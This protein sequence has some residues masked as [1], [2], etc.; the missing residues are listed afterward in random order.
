MRAKRDD[1]LRL[2]NFA[3]ELRQSSTDSESRLWS[4]VRSRQL[5]GYK[6]RRQH[7]LGGY[8][9]DFYCIREKFAVELD[10]GQHTEPGGV[11]Y[12]LARTARLNELGVRVVRYGD[13]QILQTPDSVADDIFLKLTTVLPSP[14]P[15]PGVPGEGER[16]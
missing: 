3:R 9:L 11:A 5:S 12:D 6:F 10:G 4:I 16:A 7:P 1:N 8:I 13:D 14:Q 15:S 2:R